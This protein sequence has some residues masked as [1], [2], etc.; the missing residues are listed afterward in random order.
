MKLVGR[1]ALFGSVFVASA[2][3]IFYHSSFDVSEDIAVTV[4]KKRISFWQNL[5][6]HEEVRVACV[7][8]SIT[9]GNGSHVK[10]KKKGR[11]GQLSFGACQTSFELRLSQCG[12]AKLW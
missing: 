11:R 2:V 7:G 12:R 10:K 3:F 4:L 8:D 9:F 1:I 5:C 6:S